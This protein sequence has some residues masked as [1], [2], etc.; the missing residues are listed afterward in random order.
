MKVLNLILTKEW[1]NLIK[2]GVKVEEYRE[3]K[4]YWFNRLTIENIYNIMMGAH[5]FGF[6]L[7]QPRFKTFDCVK[8]TNGYGKN[9]PSFT[10]ELD[11]IEIRNGKKEWGA[12]CG[13]KYFVIKLGKITNGDN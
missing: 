6:G 9:A 1:F 13:V 12:E 2:S 4:D 8:F 3:L 5:L 11:G 10:V 7:Y